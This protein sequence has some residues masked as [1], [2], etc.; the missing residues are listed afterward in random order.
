MG[1]MKRRQRL[2]LLAIWS[3]SL[4]LLAA[5]ID[6][7]A[8]ATEA[9]TG[10]CW[11]AGFFYRLGQL[12]QGERERVL[13]EIELR[14]ANLR[15]RQEVLVVKGE[16]LD[17]LDSRRQLYPVATILDQSGLLVQVHQFPNL[18]YGLGEPLPRHTRNTYLVV[19]NP[20]LELLESRIRQQWVIRADFVAFVQIYLEALAA[21][22]QRGAAAWPSLGR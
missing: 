11:P 1:E 15:R 9:V 19:K 22:R 18:F 8:A 2:R 14:L 7:R 16:V 3:L 6:F 20:R 17:E 5:M 4:W 10:F 13:Q 21:E 12:S